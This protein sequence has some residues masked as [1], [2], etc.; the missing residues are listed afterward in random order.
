MAVSEFESSSKSSSSDSE[1]ESNDEENKEVI[2]R[3]P[4]NFLEAFLNFIR[5]GNCKKLTH[6]DLSGITCLSSD[7]LQSVLLD[8]S[9]VFY[10][11]NILAIHLDDYGINEDEILKQDIMDLF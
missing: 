4:T 10:A 2:F 1:G 7:D 11:P 3:K 5:R 6:L 8:L 9:N